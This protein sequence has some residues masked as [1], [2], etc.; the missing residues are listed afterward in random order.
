MKLARTTDPDVYAYAATDTIDVLAHRIRVMFSQKRRFTVTRTSPDSAAFPTVTAGLTI[1]PCYHPDCD[2]IHLDPVQ[3]EPGTVR[4]LSVTATNGDPVLS[5][6]V[7]AGVTEDQSREQVEQE[8]NRANAT[9]VHVTGGLH[10]TRPGPNDQIRVRRWSPLGVP[11]D[12]IV[13]FD[14]VNGLD[15]AL[16]QADVI[17]A[18][19]NVTNTEH[20][21]TRAELAR[22]AHTLRYADPDL[23]RAA[24]T[25]IG[26][27][28]ADGS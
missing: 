18:L 20:L 14:T 12:T 26:R 15:V 17:D 28:P 22:T 6:S 3:D 13:A 1:R 11:V 8:Q 19:A 27:G 5:V 9:F 10:P 25:S 24:H 7:P 23:S 16:H 21:W 2:L 4:L